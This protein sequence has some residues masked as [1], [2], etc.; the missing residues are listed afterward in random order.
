MH[1]DLG[2]SVHRIISIMTL[3]SG[4]IRY[5]YD[6]SITIQGVLRGIAVPVSYRCDL[7]VFI[8]TKRLGIAFRVSLGYRAV[9]GIILI[10]ISV[11]VPVGQGDH[12]VVLIVGVSLGIA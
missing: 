11:A 5:G 6:I 4:C 3:G 7:A 10:S 2:K 8:V 12:I 1:G 9:Q